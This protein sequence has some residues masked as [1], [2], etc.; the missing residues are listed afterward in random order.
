MPKYCPECG[1]DLGDNP[2][3]C[4]ECG[5]QMEGKKHTGFGIASLV[6]GII[7]IC[8]IWTI[9]SGVVFLVI[10]L[11]FL[12]PIGILS[13]IFGAI[14]YRQRKLHDKYG[15][16][17]LILGILLVMSFVFYGI[18]QN[19]GL[20]SISDLEANPKNY[21]GKEVKVKGNVDFAT[22]YISDGE[23]HSFY[24]LFEN[25]SEEDLFFLSL[26]YHIDT[27]TGIVEFRN[28]SSYFGEGYY[29]KV[30]SWDGSRN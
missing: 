20:T 12:V 27:L 26:L 1:K 5:K 24:F 18:S 8:F 16:I 15:L 7:G 30:A 13:I 25:K 3:F 28:S 2:K 4:P 29:L 17:G 21:L 11:F 23:G 9:F 19:I 14:G 6:L 22:H 10:W